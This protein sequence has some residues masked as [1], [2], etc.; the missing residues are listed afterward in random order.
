[1][2][3]ALSK[4]GRKMNRKAVVNIDKFAEWFLPLIFLEIFPSEGKGIR[5]AF[6]IKD[7]VGEFC[8]RT[9]YSEDNKISMNLSEWKKIFEK[10]LEYKEI[11]GYLLNILE[12]E[13][14]YYGMSIILEIGN[15]TWNRD[16]IYFIEENE[17]NNKY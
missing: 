6:F 11:S 1:M 16:G 13:K 15:S 5:A 2:N 12:K 14:N 10:Y 17:I 8:F 9:L 7:E 3:Y 4:K